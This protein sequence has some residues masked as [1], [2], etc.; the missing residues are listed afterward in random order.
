VLYPATGGAL[1]TPVTALAAFIRSGGPIGS[2]GRW[3]VRHGRWRALP[4][5]DPSYVRV[6]LRVPLREGRSYG[7]SG[8]MLPAPRAS[9]MPPGSD[10]QRQGQAL[11]GRLTPSLDPDSV[12]ARSVRNTSATHRARRAAQ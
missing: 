4:A 7:G 8:E 6:P 9:I 3:A 12:R 2:G 11:T 10:R 5:P 1:Y